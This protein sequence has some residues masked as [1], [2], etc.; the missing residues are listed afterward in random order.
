M[1]GLQDR[2]VLRL[3]L[4]LGLL[5]EAALWRLSLGL[6]LLLEAAALSLIPTPTPTSILKPTSLS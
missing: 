3:S 6:G 4:G 5:L 2:A 1:L